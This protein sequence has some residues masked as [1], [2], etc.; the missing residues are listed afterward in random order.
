MNHVVTISGR[1]SNK[2]NT[3]ILA[4]KSSIR[5]QQRVFLPKLIPSLYSIFTL[6]FTRLAAVPVFT[7]VVL[8]WFRSIDNSLTSLLGS[9]PQ[10]LGLAADDPVPRLF[11]F[12]VGFFCNVLPIPNTSSVP[13][14]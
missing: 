2:N 1:A 11:D 4:M 7:V 8:C 3:K 14:S 9:R 13:A 10:P 12:K 5:I 6:S